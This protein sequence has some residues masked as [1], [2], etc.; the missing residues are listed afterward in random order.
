M[1]GKPKAPFY[2]A[3]GVLVIGLVAF[4]IFRA[5]LFAPAPGGGG[6]GAF[7]VHLNSLLGSPSRD[8]R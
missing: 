5:D 2:I 7:L 8:R 3:L 1:A 6:D 4:A